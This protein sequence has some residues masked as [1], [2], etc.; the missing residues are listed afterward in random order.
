MLIL[1]KTVLLSAA[2]AWKENVPG[3]CIELPTNLHQMT[4]KIV[5]Q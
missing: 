5:Q 2:Y 1:Y 3:M 4:S